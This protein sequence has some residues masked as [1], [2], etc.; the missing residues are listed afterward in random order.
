MEAGVVAN[1]L[2]FFTDA[3][4]EEIYFVLNELQAAGINYQSVDAMIDKIL[5]EYNCC[6]ESVSPNKAN[7]FN[8]PG[9]T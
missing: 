4:E 8:L 1:F 7:I 3:E 9:D 6:S 2:N 5:A